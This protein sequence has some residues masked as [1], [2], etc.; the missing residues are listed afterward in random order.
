MLSTIEAGRDIDSY[1]DE[2]L[3][4]MILLKQSKNILKSLSSNSAAQMQLMSG[5][6]CFRYII[7]NRI[8]ICSYII[9]ES[10]CFLTL[11]EKGVSKR[12][13]FSFLEDV[14]NTFLNYVQNEH[15]E[16]YATFNEIDCVDGEPFLLQWLV[17]MLMLVLVILGNLALPYR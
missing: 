10:L 14:K 6:L 1:K 17:L 3:N 15:K 13:I 11:T 12:S 7:F 9:E 2:V 4:L 5:D 8:V 16:E